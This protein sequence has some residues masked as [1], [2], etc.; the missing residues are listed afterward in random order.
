VSKVED[1][2]AL[3]QHFTSSCYAI[4]AYRFADYANHYSEDAVLEIVWQDAQGNLHPLNGGVGCR[5]SGRAQIEEFVRIN[6]DDHPP[7]P[8]PHS[9]EGHELVSRLIEV[10]GDTA[11]MRT[12]NARGHLQYEIDARREGDGWLFARI[13]IIFGADTSLPATS[14]GPLKRAANA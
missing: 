11:F 9:G 3:D 1:I 5:L 8:R 4:D 12:V 6:F 7:L 14:A 10:D 2:V 13:L